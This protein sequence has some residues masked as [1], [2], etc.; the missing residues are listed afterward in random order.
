MLG[1]TRRTFLSACGGATVGACAAAT[2]GAAQQATDSRS[3]RQIELDCRWIETTLGGTRVKLRTYNGELPGPLLEMRAGETVRIQLANSLTPYDSRGWTGNHNVPHRLD[4]TNLHL[5]GM[6]VV[7]H[8]FEP[9]G[10][11][12]PLASMIAIGPGRRK[13]YVF[14]LP[15]DHAPGFYWYHPHLHGST[16]V[17]AVSGMAGG[18]VV[19]GAIDEVP[20]IKA[21]RELFLVVSDIGL[22][23]SETT[24]DLWIYEP[25]QNSVWNT[26]TN[27]VSRWNAAKGAMEPDPSLKG[28][29]TTGDYKLRYYL[30]NGKPFYK[31]EHNNDQQRQPIGTQMPVPRFALRPGEVVRFR[32]LNANSDNLM[33]IVVEGHE[34]HLIALD[35]VNFPRT[36]TIP[37][38]WIGG[39]YGMEQVLLAPSNR[40]EFLIR[41]GTPGIYRIVQLSQSQ[42]FLVSPFKVIAEIEVAGQPIDPPMAVPDALPVPKREYPL[43]DPGEITERR[44]VV[45]TGMFPGVLNP[46]IGLDFTLNN[47]LYDERAVPIVASLGSAEEWELSVPDMSHGGSEGHPFHIHVNAFEVVSING[48]PQTPVRVKDTQWIDANTTV[49]IRMRFR[50][51]AGKTVFHCH[52]LPHEDTGMMQN[53]L[54]V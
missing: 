43:I 33:P 18:I 21:A 48:Q 4:S 2:R 45:F 6:D 11:T 50:E 17:Q 42:Q 7:P 34:M 24:P 51:F 35:G 19:R 28:G 30:V 46:I 40:A 15:A 10:T 41:A 27:T 12:N 29:F 25:V 5:H 36:Q 53:L 16:A 38:R 37:P 52:I 47:N 54:I 22:F 26:L 39:S 14:R 31:E 49:V 20:A 32:M 8:L 3:A 13:E 1:V 23:P 9:I 44:S